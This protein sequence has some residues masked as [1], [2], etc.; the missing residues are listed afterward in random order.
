MAGPSTAPENIDAHFIGATA[1]FVLLH[2]GSSARARL[3]CRLTKNASSCGPPS[4]SSGYGSGVKVASVP[5]RGCQALVLCPR[6][7]AQ[8]PLGCH[9]APLSRRCS[10]APGH[11]GLPNSLASPFMPVGL[12]RFVL[13]LRCH[14]SLPPP[15]TSG[16]RHWQ[17]A[18]LSTAPS[19]RGG[20]LYSLAQRHRHAK[21]GAN[22]GLVAPFTSAF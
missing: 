14:G 16:Q 2:L 10:V 22:I 3:V 1:V 5:A 7:G 18:T 4:S 20:R 15:V 11:V 6:C 12:V 19:H 8:L 9:S 13:L 21:P 17:I